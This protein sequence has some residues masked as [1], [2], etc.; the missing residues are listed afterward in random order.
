MERKSG[1][2]RGIGRLS[3]GIIRRKNLVGNGRRIGE[4]RRIG[5]W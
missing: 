1:M 4:V 2:G 5:S 3:I